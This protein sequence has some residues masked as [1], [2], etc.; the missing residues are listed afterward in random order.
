[1]DRSRYGD[2][3]DCMS[4]RRQP[5]ELIT[6]EELERMRPELEIVQHEEPRE[7]PPPPFVH[8]DAFK[9]HRKTPQA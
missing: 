1:M 2:Y 8:P 5:D 7:E 3:A 6:W 9:R 4:Y